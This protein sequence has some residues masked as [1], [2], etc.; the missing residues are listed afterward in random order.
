MHREIALWAGRVCPFVC[1]VDFS[2]ELLDGLGW[3]LIWR[4]CYSSRPQNR[5]LEDPT[6]GVN[7]NEENPKMDIGVLPSGGQVGWRN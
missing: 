6:S 5:A 2:R 4:L 1:S 3:N 7:K